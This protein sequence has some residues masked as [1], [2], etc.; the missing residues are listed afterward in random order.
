MADKASAH[1]HKE[2]FV[3]MITKDIALDACVLDLVDNAVDGATRALGAKW[4]RDKAY[5]PYKI[6]LTFDAKEFEIADNCGGIAYA[7]ARDYAFRFGRDPN[8]GPDTKHGIGLYGIGMK[9]AL[10]KIGRD[11]KVVSST[12]TEGFEVAIDVSD[13][14]SEDGWEF[15][16]KKKTTHESSTTITV[17]SLSDGIGDDFKDSVFENRLVRT[18]SRVYT[19][20]IARG[21]TVEIN[22]KSIDAQPF[23]LK[24]NKEFKPYTT[25]FEQGG[26]TVSIVAGLAE[27]PPEDDSAEAEIPK[28][29]YYGWYVVCNERIIIAGNKTD[30]TVWGE[31]GFQSWHPQ[32]SGF[33][34]LVMFDAADPLKLP[35][36]TTK[37]DVDLTSAVYRRA[38]VKMKEATKQY[39]T[40]TT[41]RKA[42]LQK[43]R[44]LE[45]KAPAVSAFEVVGKNQN[46]KMVVPKIQEPTGPEL[47]NIQYQKSTIEVEQAAAALGNPRMSAKMVGTKTFEYFVKNEVD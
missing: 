31:D 25:T 16:L 21:L 1:P 27:P 13:W 26:V 29:D 28:I 7:D 10:F 9:R 32:Y 47:V 23:T 43:A 37:T 36:G 46:Q 34:G 33:L 42:S 41:K 18:I 3:H 19:R 30:R 8:E 2:F 22:G 12:D 35:W 24:S 38:V 6:S 17:K 40:Y 11:I 39:I 5:E 4:K 15:D 45:K 14:A 44:D 20:F